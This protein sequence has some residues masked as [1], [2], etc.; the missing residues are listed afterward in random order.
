MQS[1]VPQ[2]LV[3]DLAQLSSSQTLWCLGCMSRCFLGNWETNL[4]VVISMESPEFSWHQIL[5]SYL[6]IHL[7][8]SINCQNLLEFLDF[9]LQTRGLFR[10]C[11]PFRLSLFFPHVSNPSGTRTLLVAGTL[12]GAGKRDVFPASAGVSEG[13][14]LRLFFSPAFQSL[15]CPVAAL[16][17]DRSVEENPPEHWVLQPPAEEWPTPLS[18][19]MPDH[20]RWDA[21]ICPFLA[22]P[23]KSQFRGRSSVCKDFRVVW[24]LSEMTTKWE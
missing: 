11:H 7:S 19:P 21:E 1:P 15:P 22:L 4:Y 17:S 5:Q 3:W 10:R 8:Y 16:V 9:C 2:C 24:F 14:W 13:G 12:I 23:R 18:L 20:E 6:Q